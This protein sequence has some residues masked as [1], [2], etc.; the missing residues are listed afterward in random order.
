MPTTWTLGCELGNLTGE[1]QYRWSIADKADVVKAASGVVEKFR[2]VGLP[3]L[4]RFSSLE[5]VLEVLSGDDK[6]AWLHSAIHDCRAMRAIA[7]AYLLKRKQECL[8]LI[9][10]KTHFLEQRNSFGLNGFPEMTS[11]LKA[12]LL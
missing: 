10:K 12:R 6:A 4:E 1:G 11:A 9:E 7:A 8:E 3:Y 5:I 2:A